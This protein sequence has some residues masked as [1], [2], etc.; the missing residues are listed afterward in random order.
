M[1]RAGVF[2]HLPTMRR[3]Q[4]G[5][6]EDKS[7]TAYVEARGEIVKSWLLPLGKKRDPVALADLKVGDDVF[8]LRAVGTMADT[9]AGMDDG[10][11]VK[12]VGKLRR[13]A[14]KRA[15]QTEQERVVIAVKTL[16]TWQRK[17]P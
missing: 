13:M 8:G 17:K 4:M 14:W 16:E 12:V 15:D 9:L 1:Q 3:R 10:A 2:G 6:R 7:E 5:N 11:P